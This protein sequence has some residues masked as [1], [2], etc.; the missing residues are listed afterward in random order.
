MHFYVHDIVF[1]TMNSLCKSL[2]ARH[3][4]LLPVGKLNQAIII[5]NPQKIVG[6]LYQ[7]DKSN[8]FLCAWHAIVFVTMN[9]IYKSLRVRRLIFYHRW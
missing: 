1:V 2:S 4:I 7:H 8:A 5:E 3:L 6:E 9:S